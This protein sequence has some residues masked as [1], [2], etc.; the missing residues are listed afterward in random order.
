MK[1]S[2]QIHASLLGSG[3]TW[4]TAAESAAFRIRGHYP[5]W[6]AFPDGSP[7]M[8]ICNSV[9]VLVRSLRSPSTPKQQRHQA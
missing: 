8:L 7:T 1:W 6:P 3:V 4:D 9:T 2:S 5:L